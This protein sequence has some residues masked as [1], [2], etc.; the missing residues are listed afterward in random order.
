MAIDLREIRAAVINYVDSKVTV[1]IS[2]PAPVS[3]AVINPNEMFSFTLTAKNA[4]A[5]SGGIPLRDVIWHVWVQDEAVCKLIVPVPIG[6]VLL[7]VARSGPSSAYPQL[8]PGSEVREMYLFPKSNKV[9]YLWIGETETITLQGKAGADPEGGI[10]SI[11][12]KVYANVD[13]DWLF[14][15]KQDTVIAIEMLN[16]TGATPN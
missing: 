4:D 6:H 15:Q 16:V 8:A 11:Q 13:M 7:V 2:T 12:F 3:G 1:S 9:R 14:P 10:T 5:A